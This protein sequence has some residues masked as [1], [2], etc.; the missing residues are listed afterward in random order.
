MLGWNA[1]GRDDIGKAGT[2]AAAVYDSHVEPHAAPG[3]AGMTTS[4][5]SS[6]PSASDSDKVGKRS[7]RQVTR[8]NAQFRSAVVVFLFKTSSIIVLRG[9]CVNTIYR[10]VIRAIRA[11]LTG[12]K[13]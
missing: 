12:G 2:A 4:K 1:L 10:S 5:G 13:T 8:I 9:R 7:C 11:V 3:T 6:C